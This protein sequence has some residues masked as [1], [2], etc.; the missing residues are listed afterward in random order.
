[1]TQSRLSQ[2]NVDE[3][4]YY[5]C[6][7][8]CV[9]RAFL[10]GDDRYSGKNFDHRKQWVV[11]RMRFLT[12]VFAIDVCAYAV[13]SNHLHLVL[14][15]DRERA[16]S[17]GA[18]EVLRRYSKLFR[19]ANAQYQAVGPEQK[20][21]LV[22]LWR[23]RLWD[24][25]WMMRS[26]TESIARRANREDDCKGRFWEGRFK[27]Q[28]LLDTEGLLTCMAYV[29]LNPVRA[30]MADTLEASDFTSIQER[31]QHAAK[32]RKQRKRVT[33]PETLAPFSH[34]GLPE[35]HQPKV[36][37]KAD[38]TA[39][40]SGN[41][42]AR[43][44]SARKPLPIDFVAYL[45]LLQWTGR[46]LSERADGCLRDTPPALLRELGLDSGAWLNALSAHRLAT[47]TALG[48]PEHLETHAAHCGRAWLR[49]VGLAKALAA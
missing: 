39:R 35:A 46:A 15:V 7:T 44:A 47:A 31:L 40:R 20:A 30:G 1:M 12:A 26:L 13:M 21:A 19:G 2:V 17:W 8:R 42:D 34:S 11:E 41:R 36:D 37:Q 49:G 28:A 45:D 9:R 6:M 43:G 16:L 5:H 10:C 48:T 33:A 29:D 14:H 3:T 23:S 32:Q 27:S 18:D 22:E 38:R 25:S 4:P 24:L